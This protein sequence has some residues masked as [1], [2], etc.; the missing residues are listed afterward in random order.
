MNGICFQDFVN[1]N[2][3]SP[4]GPQAKTP[5]SPTHRAQK[6][7]FGSSCAVNNGN[8]AADSANSVRD[9]NSCKSVEESSTECAGKSKFDVFRLHIRY[10][11]KLKLIYKSS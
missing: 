3:I 8:L 10:K 1:N 6:Q 5:L 2:L 7:P 4:I 9:K 11:V